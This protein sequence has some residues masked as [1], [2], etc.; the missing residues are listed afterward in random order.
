MSHLFT[1]DDGKSVFTD[2]SEWFWGFRKW[3]RLIGETLVIAY[4][5]TALGGLGALILCF[6]ASANITSNR[7]V[8]VFLSRRLL[9][10]FRTVP[11]M[12]F[13]LISVVA[14]GLGPFPGRPGPGDP[15]NGCAANS[16]PRSSRTS[17]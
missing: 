9:E 10:F 16:S 3:S 1:L 11:E 4:L 17:I 5:G 8:F 13:A 7:L 6:L 12:V 15:Y 2:V 14:F